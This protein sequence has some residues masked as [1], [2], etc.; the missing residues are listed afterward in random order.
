MALSNVQAMY[1][2]FLPQIPDACQDNMLTLACANA[3]LPLCQG[4]S[5]RGISSLMDGNSN[6]NVWKNNVE[7][8]WDFDSI[9]YNPI[10]TVLDT[11]IDAFCT[12]N[13][14]INSNE[15]TCVNFPS[16][17]A[18][19]C[20]VQAAAGRGCDVSNRKDCPGKIFSRVGG[21]FVVQ[22][23]AGN[24]TTPRYILVEFPQCIPFFCWNELCWNTT[25]LLPS[26]IRSSRNSCADGI[27]LNIQ[28][29]DRIT[30]SDLTPP[31]NPDSFRPRQILMSNCGRGHAPANPTLI[32][33]QWTTPVN[34]TYALPFALTNNGDDIL[35]MTLSSVSFN[36]NFGATT[37]QFLTV[38]PH[39]S[40]QFNMF[41]DTT[42]LLQSWQKST[43]VEQT[44][45]VT[46]T[47]IP[48]LQ[49]PCPTDPFFL[50]APVFWYTFSSNLS[51]QT[52]SFNPEMVLTPPVDN[53]ADTLEPVTNARIPWSVNIAGIAAVVFV[54]FA[55]AVLFASEK[56]A[57]NAMNLL[58]P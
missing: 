31:P 55:L 13:A 28:G 45:N 10:Q 51:V 17:Q 14:G 23:K 20:S 56:T 5:A 3:M 37:P 16:A 39:G 12:S 34:N 11:A 40:L 25:S 46:V 50:R 18:A 48:C 8:A 24:N 54:L 4:L 33:T 6:C 57:L 29:V 26:Y 35:N 15:C 19:Q 22:D 32:P 21:G 47:H 49:Q 36:E 30:V 9:T 1:P 44:R 52:F 27:C 53:Q 43:N 38:G 2:G 7:T 58:I 41:F 42:K